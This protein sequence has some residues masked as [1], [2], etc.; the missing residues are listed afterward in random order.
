MSRVRYAWLV[1][2]SFYE[3]ARY[4]VIRQVLEKRS[5]Q[6]SCGRG[7]TRTGGARD[8]RDEAVMCRAFA[9][10]TCLYWKPVRCL[11]RSTCL[12]R[13]LRHHGVLARLVIGYRAVPFF[14]HAWVEVDGRIVDDS[15]V[16][17]QRLRVLFTS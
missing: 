15:P 7:A 4:D 9:L 11:Q 12:V 16:Y 14:S 3:L 6:P 5:I 10:A 17:Q 1:A 2:C 8:E 13:L